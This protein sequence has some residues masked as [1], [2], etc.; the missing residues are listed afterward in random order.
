[1]F[2]MT[3]PG[4]SRA[5][6]LFV[7]L[8]LI[9]Q[10]A[11]SRALS[12]PERNLPLPE[13]NKLPRELGRWKVTEEQSLDRGVTEYLKPDEYVLWNYAIE[14][15]GASINLFAAYFKSLQNS[16]GPHSPRVCLPGAGWLV[17]SSKIAMIA[18]PGRTAGI[19]VNVYTLEKASEHILVMYWYQNN[20]S[21]WAEEFRAKLTLLPDLLRYRRSDVCL[22]RLTT[23]LHG[24]V[25]DAAMADSMAFLKLLFPPLVERFEATKYVISR[26]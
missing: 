18:V 20:R 1:M 3:Q 4:G 25:D 11:A 17:R 23:R 5:L 8:I 26:Y 22:I 16:Y 10:V 21:I 12:L 13:L 19:P 6:F 15:S 7:C 24:E 9:L 14:N 2:N